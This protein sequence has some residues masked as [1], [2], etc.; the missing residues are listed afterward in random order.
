MMWPS[1][2]P[3]TGSQAARYTG[4]GY[5]TP[6]MHDVFMSTGAGRRVPRH[7]PA[8]DL[9]NEQTHADRRQ[10]KAKVLKISTKT[11][12]TCELQCQLQQ[13]SSTTLSTYLHR[14]QIVHLILQRRH[15]A[16][17][18]LGVADFCTLTQAKGQ[19]T[20]R[21]CRR[22]SVRHCCQERPNQNSQ[23]ASEQCQKSIIESG[24]ATAHH[25]SAPRLQLTCHLQPPHP[26]DQ[27]AQVR[28]SPFHQACNS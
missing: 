27:A 9:A 6:R 12:Q 25:L 19:Q 15:K 7:H 23:R 24:R 14:C 20:C 21:A 16:H 18:S 4:L 8:S 26:C 11:L 22:F 1:K 2:R 17:R 10:G 5:R 28:L 3:H 13:Q